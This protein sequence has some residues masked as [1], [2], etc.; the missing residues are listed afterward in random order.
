MEASTDDNE[1][2]LKDIKKFPYIYWL[3][4]INCVCNYV[5]FVV[6]MQYLGALL[7]DKYQVDSL[8]VGRLITIPYF[9]GAGLI[10]FA[11]ALIDKIG[12]R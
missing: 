9:M 8:I 3:I 10:P 2:S 11:A 1:V 4:L 6:F 12:N 5:C 7:L